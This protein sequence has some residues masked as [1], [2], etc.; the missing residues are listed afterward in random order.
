[1]TDETRALSVGTPLDHFVLLTLDLERAS[2]VFAE[3]GFTVTPRTDHSAEMGTANRCVMLSST[4][5][6]LLTVVRATE[7][8]SGWQVLMNEGGGIRGI[9]LR[10]R[11]AR[12]AC[13]ALLA[14]GFATGQVIAFE[15][16]DERG[17]RLR[18]QVC[19]LPA[20]DTPGF[21]LIVCAHE[22]PELVWRPEWTRHPNGAIELSAA[23]IGVPDPIAAA[24]VL[25]HVSGSLPDSAQSGHLTTVTLC[26][27]TEL[28][29]LR[30]SIADLGTAERIVRGSRFP[31]RFQRDEITIDLRAE[32]GV[33]LGLEP[34]Q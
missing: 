25:R 10:T 34:V 11:N 3:L 5:I 30:L 31:A 26:S 18:F 27:A 8:S 32:L 29:H 9:A 17:N 16:P 23:D 6:E 19:R 21:R 14:A 22:T 4:Y 20:P 12:S 13:K 1:M 15:R 24:D 7:R 33:V 28:N 2:N